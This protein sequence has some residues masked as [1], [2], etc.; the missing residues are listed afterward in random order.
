MNKETLKYIITDFHENKLPATK[1][2]SIKLP[3]KAKGSAEADPEINKIISLVGVRRS[4]KTFLFYHTIR[5]LIKNGVDKKNIIYIN[6]EDDRLFPIELSQMNL[7]LKAYHELYPDKVDE[8]KYLFFDEIQVVDNWE[9]YIRRIHDTE[10]A[11]ICITGSS[12]QLLSRDIS[13]SLRGRSISYEITPLT[14]REH[15]NFK[16]VSIKKYSR[17]AEAQ[18]RHE[19]NEYLEYGGFPEIVLA[20][21]K[22]IKGKILRE[23]VD[24]IQYKDMVERYNVQNQFLLKTL[25]K[26]C[27]THPANLISVNKLYN[28]FK[29]QGISL[30]KNTLYEYLEYMQE[31]FIISLN[32]KYSDSIRKQQQKPKKL[33]I[34]D[35]SLMLPF[36][37]SKKINIGYRLENCVF[38]NLYKMYENIYYYAN[39]YEV[40]FV[41]EDHGGLEI[42]NVSDNIEERD[43]RLR[44]INSLKKARERFPNAKLNLVINQYQKIEDKEINCLSVIDFLLKEDKKDI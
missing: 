14:F 20:D 2:R 30:S 3:L 38:R 26:F 7:I 4:G 25:L 18:I 36:V 12:S 22:I 11:R 24:L 17:K 15:L 21:D 16:E 41:V 13:T 19:F 29:S 27:F 43:T 1:A 5:S 6:F 33:Y 35:N 32:P 28:D 37:S 9:K 39:K 31:S 42:F 10:N 34:I 8:K 23:Y 44:E 40:D